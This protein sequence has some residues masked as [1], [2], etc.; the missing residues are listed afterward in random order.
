MIGACAEAVDCRVR[1]TERGGDGMVERGYGI[2]DQLNEW[3]EQASVAF[4]FPYGSRTIVHTG[5]R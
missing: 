4:G 1:Y 5:R 3:C 2:A